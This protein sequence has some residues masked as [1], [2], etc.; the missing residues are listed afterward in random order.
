MK[1]IIT[2]LALLFLTAYSYAEQ[3]SPS[4]RVKSN[5]NIRSTPSTDL[6]PIGVLLPNESL[7]F[8]SSESGWYKV[9]YKGQTGYVSKSWSVLLDD[10]P[11]TLHAIDVG[12]GLAIL[13]QGPDFN[14]IY[15]GGSN[16]DAGRGE[17]NRLIAYLSEKLPQLNR[18]DHVVLSHPHK[19][20]VEL[21][22]DLFDKYT[23]GNAWDSGAVNDICGYRAFVKQIATKKV[24]YHTAKN[25]AGD[26]EVSFTKDSGK[27]YGQPRTAFKEKVSFTSK[28]T[29]KVIPLGNN[30][31]MQ[32]LYANGEQH[33]SYNENSLVMM[34][35][36]GNK[37][38]LF[39]GDSEGGAR[40]NW[41]NAEP[42]K[43]SV[44]AELLELPA[45]Q[46]KADMLIVG[47]HG[48]RTSSRKNFLQAVSAKHYV[49]SAGP[50]KYGSV[51]LPDDIV[52]DEL[53]GLGKVYRTDT[54]D[55]ECLVST[56][57]VGNKNDGKP[58]GCSN[59]KFK[60][61]TNSISSSQL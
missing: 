60:L 58:G 12:T 19:D 34:M 15:D 26:G 4:D 47:H 50:K 9:K 42:K 10:T 6:Q 5:L 8:I 46:L 25:E 31:S 52:I 48:S 44:E 22:P 40:K 16:D 41:T 17:N 23:I 43:S 2:I 57:K 35:T 49:V 32:F 14:L 37:R 1:P 28:I 21:L 13:V 59:F 61:S 3:V 55:T 11:Y 27:C 24:K 36:L 29:D 18:I 53:S 54:D 7:E 56:T 51:V 39:T 38:I 30:A 33:S 20:H 45:E